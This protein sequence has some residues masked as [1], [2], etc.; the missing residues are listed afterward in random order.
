MSEL[1]DLV[2]SRLDPQSL[3]QITQMLGGDE[4][5]TRNA[6]E[7][8]LP[9]LLAGLNR[10]AAQGGAEAIGQAIERDHDGSILDDVAGFLNRGPS[11]AD[12]RIVDHI[13]G[14]GRGRIEQNIGQSSGLSSDK[15]GQLLATLAPLVMGA[16]GRQQRQTGG[17]LGSLIDALGSA[18]RSAR[19]KPGGGVLGSL[20]DGDG[21]GDV[22]V[23]DLTKLGG[24]LL[25]QFFK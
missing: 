25:G 9:M 4:A 8:A 10:N 2:A 11:Q 21:D 6:I 16:A 20:L 15:V 5:G 17:G 18:D 13:F 19:Q 12:N 1:F 24:G 7:S 23:A 14:Q 3:G 22:D